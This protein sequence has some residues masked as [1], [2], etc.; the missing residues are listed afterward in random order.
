MMES[1]WYFGYGSNMKS[2][3][4]ANR[5]ITPLSVKVGLVPTF[6]LTFDIFEIPYTEPSFE[7]IALY[8]EKTEVAAEGVT[9]PPVHGVLY[10]LEREDYLRLVRSEGSGVGYDEIT[11]EAYILETQADGTVIAT[12]ECI[13]AQT[14]KAKYPWRPNPGP[15]QRYMGLLLDGCKE[16]KLPSSYLRYLETLPVYVQADK[17]SIL[18]TTGS[19]LFLAFWGRVI[20]MLAQTTKV[21]VNDQGHAPLWLGWVIVGVYRLMWLWH[22]NIHAKIWRLGHGELIN[23]GA[24]SNL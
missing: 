14:L 5:G 22:D 16:H 10:Q 3:V 9:I 18:Q 23:Y 21:V 20:R 1:V 15:S 17:I 12:E 24:V 4:M 8:P 19:S 11:V 6:I 2:S 13:M 7:S